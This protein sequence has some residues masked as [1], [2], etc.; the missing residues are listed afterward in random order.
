M[1][2]SELQQWVAGSWRDRPTEDRPTTEQQ[3]LFIIEE[4]GEVAEAIRK[5]QGNK[6]H[7]DFEANLG[8]EFA[9]MII[10]LVTLANSHNVDL[11]GEI[12]Q[13][14]TKITKRRQSR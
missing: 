2:I 4:F 6:K 12:E 13:F 9:D 8:S 14:K 3:L 1:T 11:D 10:S 5:G 7:K